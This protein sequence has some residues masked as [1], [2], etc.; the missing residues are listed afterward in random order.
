MAG[1]A[2]CLLAASMAFAQSA[3]R[4]PLAPE[5]G[6][7]ADAVLDQRG[8]VRPVQPA[9][10]APGRRKWTVEIHG[11]GFA[12]IGSPDGTAALP[13]AGDPFTTFSGFPSRRVSSWFIGDGTVFFNELPPGV[14]GGRTMTS[15]DPAL[16]MFAER[17]S[18]GAGLGSRVAYAVTP[19]LAAEV[20]VDY[21]LSQLSMD[22]RVPALVETSRL[23]F[24]DAW[25]GATAVFT[26]SS[27]ST[28]TSFR[29]SGGRRLQVVGAAVWSFHEIAGL[30]P[31]VT[32]GAGVTAA[33]G[34]PPTAIV[35]GHYSFRSS[36]LNGRFE[37][38]DTVTV[39]YGMARTPVG[40]IGGGF[41]VDAGRRSGLRVDVRGSFGPSPLRTTVEAHPSFTPSAPA[42]VT[43]SLTI[44]A[45][46][47]ANNLNSSNG[48]TLNGALREFVTFRSDHWTGWVA[49][50]AGWFVRF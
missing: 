45:L 16:H 19:R 7:A 44:P 21:G 46:Q 29:A 17:R 34:T 32:G 43:S 40:M 42:V 22:D 48:S 47:F 8:A 2:C 9:P 5:R 28:D 41:T 35:T 3:A 12:D 1:A 49:A 30:R 4:V 26:A 24:V 10:K 11:G 25:T 14:R 23:A 18:R 15:M 37:E 50:T 20:T 38:V 31:F 6:S 39:R 33:V 27:V 36:L 13:P